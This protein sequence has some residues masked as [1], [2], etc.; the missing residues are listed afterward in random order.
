MAARRIRTKIYEAPFNQWEA[1]LIDPASGLARFRPDVV[2]LTLTSL[3]L[4]FHNPS[5]SPQ[6]LADRISDLLMAA[7]SRLS[8]HLV[9]TLPEP[10]PEEVDS[11]VWSFEWRR[12][13]EQRLHERLES[14]AI[15]VDLEPLMRQVG[16]SRWHGERFYVASKMAFHPNQTA[17]YADYLARFVASQLNHPVKLIVVDLDNTLWGGVVGEVGWENVDLDLGGQGLGYLRLQRFLL[18]LYQKGVLL[19]VASK[20]NPG[21]ALAVFDRRPEMVLK[22]EHFVDMRVNWE[23]KSVNLSA[24]LESLNLS[25]AGVAVLDDSPVEREEIR[26]TSPEVFVPELVADPTERVSELI[27]SGQFL[28]VSARSEDLQ[29]QAFYRTEQER[30]ALKAT[31][32]TLADYYYSLGMVLE[33]AVIGVANLGRTLDLI[34][35]TNQ[36]N[37][38]SRRHSHQA[39]Q[40]L[41]V[42]PG[43]YGYVFRL[44]DSFGDYGIVGVLIAVPI[45]DGSFG[46]DTW[47]L[48]CRAMSRTV[49]YAMFEH[50]TQELRKGGAHRLV[51][52]YVPTAK[53][54]PVADLFLRLGFASVDSVSDGRHRYQLDLGMLSSP[55]HYLT[56][57]AAA[58]HVE[59]ASDHRP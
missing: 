37:P 31:A 22:R 2:L 50:L 44:K 8:C 47:L 6:A 17:R 12:S 20:N 58:E 16:S 3:S 4:P 11:T 39:L 41:L 5:L 49:E 53:N 56:I 57:A 45:G 30:R 38:T 55:R 29:R 59:S 42:T 15:L 10:L 54:A 14:D 21:D 48:S 7:K 36:F 19:A 25:T 51:G 33:P 9:V 32:Q 52:E 28:V 46:I 1:E 35:K 23:P 27:A 40:H 24:I 26:R 34:A 43:A 13:I 18:S